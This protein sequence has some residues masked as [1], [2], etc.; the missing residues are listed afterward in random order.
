MDEAQLAEALKALAAPS[1]LKIMELLRLRPYC[2]RALTILLDIS[3]PAVSQHLGVLKR[4]GLVDAD[5]KGTM[6]H[7]RANQERFQSVIKALGIVGH[8][9]DSVRK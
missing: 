3:Q 8:I 6:V 9:D 2:V 1:R 4:V 7:Y 5:K